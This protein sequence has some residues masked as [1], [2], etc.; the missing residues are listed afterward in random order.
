MASHYEC[1]PVS[2]S[3]CIAVGG[4]EEQYVMIAPPCMASGNMPPIA[5][6]QRSFTSSSASF[7]DSNVTF[8]TFERIIGVDSFSINGTSRSLKVAGVILNDIS[9]PLITKCLEDGVH[10]FK[11]HVRTKN[12]GLMWEKGKPDFVEYVGRGGLLQTSLKCHCF[13]SAHGNI[14]W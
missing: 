7:S 4:G 1:L 12:D 14:Y 6:V 5:S 9:S 11:S 2:T 8:N 3:S 10:V 13:F